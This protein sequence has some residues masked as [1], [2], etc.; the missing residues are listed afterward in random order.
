MRWIQNFHP[1]FF[2][3]IRHWRFLFIFLV[4]QVLQVTPRA[5][6]APRA[7]VFQNPFLWFRIGVSLCL[8][9]EYTLSYLRYASQNLHFELLGSK[10]S[11]W[12]FFTVSFRHIRIVLQP[13]SVSILETEATTVLFFRIDNDSMCVVALIYTS[14]K[15]RCSMQNSLPHFNKICSFIYEWRHN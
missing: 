10:P 6:L 5:P 7:K 12:N 1:S 14:I 15:A 4:L 8:R 11:W 13:L 9:V 3:C 2:L